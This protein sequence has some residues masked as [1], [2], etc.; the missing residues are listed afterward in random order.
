MNGEQCFNEAQYRGEARGLRIDLHIIISKQQE[1]KQ[2]GKAI[3]SDYKN[4]YSE[5]TLNFINFIF[6]Q[7]MIEFIYMF[8][9]ER[10]SNVCH[11]EAAN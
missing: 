5:L 3:Q 7:M 10:N 6:H 9:K 8:Q 1:E 11:T 2:V 4:V